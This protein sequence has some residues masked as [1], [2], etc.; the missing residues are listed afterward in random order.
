[1]A[2]SRSNGRTPTPAHLQEVQTWAQYY[3]EVRE[4][5]PVHLPFQGKNPHYAWRDAPAKPEDFT[6]NE[7][8][9][10]LAVGASSHGL[11]DVDLD[12]MAALVLA[13]YFLPPTKMKS[14]HSLSEESHW[15]YVCETNLPPKIS[16]FDGI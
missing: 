7:G 10:G 2:S 6:G 3:L 9:I 15:W 13:P 11:V 12:C 16:A 5:H 14:G 4:W 8:N 1:M